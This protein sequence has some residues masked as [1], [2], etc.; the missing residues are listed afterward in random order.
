[1]RP[2]RIALNHLAAPIGTEAVGD[3]LTRDQIYTCWR[4]RPL[5]GFV[6]FVDDDVFEN[7]VFKWGPY[8][9]ASMQMMAAR[10][11]TSTSNS[12]TC[13]LSA[14]ALGFFQPTEDLM[15]IAPAP[16]HPRRQ[17]LKARQG[18]DQPIVYRGACDAIVWSNYCGVIAGASSLTYVSNALAAP[19]CSRSMELVD[20]GE[21]STDD[22]SV[23]SRESCTFPITLRGV[24][25][26]S[27][28]SRKPAHGKLKKLNVATY[29]YKTKARYKGNDTFA[30]KAT[31]R[32]LLARRYHSAR[33]HQVGGLN[34][35][36]TPRNVSIQSFV[37][38]PY[39]WIC[40]DSFFSKF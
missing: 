14:A 30:I 24:M 18:Q 40:L 35:R 8:S 23:A 20:W 37:Y 22:I 25:S 31:G 15:A 33:D 10:R 16:R 19:E 29:E 1:L 28:I 12:R 27:E 39:G 21:N 2:T 32:K 6:R 34:N 17:L 13:S 26:S 38:E 9:A 36:A 4:E 5:S 11:S 3:L 7:V